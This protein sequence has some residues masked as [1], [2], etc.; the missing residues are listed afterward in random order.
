MENLHTM[1]DNELDRYIQGLPEEEFRE[2]IDN[3][4]NKSQ[5]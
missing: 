4:I 3:L 2:L 5:T 1:S